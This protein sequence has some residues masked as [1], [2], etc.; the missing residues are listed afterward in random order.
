VS[1]SPSVNG[2]DNG[3][4]A[5]LNAAD[6]SAIRAVLVLRE[7]FFLVFDMVSKRVYDFLGGVKRVKLE[8]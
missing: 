3:L 5:A 2:E 1:S 7:V 8:V 6:A 4:S